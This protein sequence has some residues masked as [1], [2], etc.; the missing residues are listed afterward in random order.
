VTVVR[1]VVGPALRRRW[2]ALLVA[3]LVLGLLGGLSLAALAGAR[4]TASAYTRF[5]EAGHPS[6]L[7]VNNFSAEGSSPRVFDDFP[8]VERI[9]SWTAFNVA[10][11]DDDGNP[12]FENA[13]GEVTGSI[14]GEYFD[15]DRVAVLEGRLPAIDSVDEILINEYSKAY[16]GFQVGEHVRI[17]FYTDEQ[18]EDDSFFEDP[19]PPLDEVEVTVVGVGLFPDEVVQDESDRIPRYLLSPAFTAK[20]MAAASYTWH[21]LVL[22]G[23]DADI[24]AVQDHFIS[25]LPDASG[26][27]FR[28]R[29]VDDN[30]AQGAVRPL[31]LALAFFGA[32]AAL[33]TLALVGQ[34]LARLIRNGATNDDVLRAL[35]ADRRTI[36]GAALVIAS[37]PIVAGSVLAAALS[38]ALSPATPVGVVRRI[39]VDPGVAV[40]WGVV[41]GGLLLLVIALSTIVLATI[42]T[43]DRARTRVPRPS[44][45]VQL[46]ASAG[47]PPAAVVGTRLALEPGTGTTTVPVRSVLVGTVVAIGA[48]TAA[49][50][51]ATS[52]DALVRTPR[53]YGWDWD[54]TLLDTSGYGGIDPVGASTLLDDPRVEAWAPIYFGA[55]DIDGRNVPLL[56][57]DPRSEVVPPILTGRTVADEGEIVLG[58][59]TLDALGKDVGDDV[60]L[61]GGGHPGT[62][63]I[64][65]TAT[66]PAIGQVHG[67][68]PSLGVGGLVDVAAV[69]GALG[70]GLGPPAMFVRYPEGADRR[71]TAA[72]LRDGTQGLGEFPGS[73]EV[74]HFREPA[75]IVNSDDIG[76]APTLVATT[77]GLAALA[78]L[79]LVLA[80][81]TTRRRRDLALL[82]GLGFTRRDVTTAVAWQATVT[83]VIGLVLGIP[84]GVATGSWIWRLFAHRL[85]V[86]PTPTVPVLALAALALAALVLCNLVAAGPGRV[87]GRTRAAMALRAE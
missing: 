7:A 8:E 23:G 18:L 53:L 65:G 40:D 75:E 56:G 2:R 26:A 48:L 20:E 27:V 4:R 42:A 38:I 51:F 29:S 14:D 52:L 6:D 50:C 47:L 3:T 15:Q 13:G 12:Q 85:Y 21:H 70:D 5:V 66:F 69:P 72:W 59:A 67:N 31:A 83:V 28:V 11:L 25:L 60:V 61:D 44:R 10:V 43:Q 73:T 9:R 79:A 17:G 46:A 1:A 41:G 49:L 80:V 19:T 86:V 16:D 32:A 74:F 22:R 57:V 30:R 36:W 58:T 33:A 84:L 76:A 62:F 45:P 68:H 64:V 34:G 24:A 54:A 55:D 35:G 63:R 77:L 39:E 78:S 37:V 81:S 71:A 82:K 87:A